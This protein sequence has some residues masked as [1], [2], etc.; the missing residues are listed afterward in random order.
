[1]LAETLHVR[2]HHMQGV[3]LRMQPLDTKIS[4]MGL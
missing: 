1:M 2:S 3:A 4:L